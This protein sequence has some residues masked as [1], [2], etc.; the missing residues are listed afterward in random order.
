ML[1]AKQELS[2][3]TRPLG[4]LYKHREPCDPFVV[5]SESVPKRNIRS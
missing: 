5:S 3:R 1:Q 4:E 2:Q